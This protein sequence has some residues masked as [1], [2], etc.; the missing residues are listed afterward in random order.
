MKIGMLKFLILLFKA[1]VFFKLAGCFDLEIIINHLKFVE[2][3]PGF[4]FF[5]KK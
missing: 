2:Q 1:K 4:D 5:L 3:S